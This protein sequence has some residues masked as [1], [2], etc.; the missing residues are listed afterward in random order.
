MIRRTDPTFDAKAFGSKFLNAAD[1]AH[2][3]DGLRRAGLYPTGA[4]AEK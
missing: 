1:L 4:P 2:L 3:R